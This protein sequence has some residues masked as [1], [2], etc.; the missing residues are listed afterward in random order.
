VTQKQKVFV[1]PDTREPLRPCPVCHKR[2]DASLCLSTERFHSGMRIGDVSLCG[3]CH[4]MLVL[5]IDGQFR[6]A[7]DAYLEDADPI[8]MR[9]LGEFEKRKEGYRDQ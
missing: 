1:G 7:D 5:A 8:V 3:Y 6:V 4:A 2:L 9:I